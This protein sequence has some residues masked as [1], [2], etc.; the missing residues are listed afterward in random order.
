MIFKSLLPVKS[1]YSELYYFKNFSRIPN[2]PFQGYSS[3]LTAMCSCDDEEALSKCM[4]LGACFHVLKPLD[5]RSFSILWH[6][7]RWPSISLYRWAASW[8]PHPHTHSAKGRRRRWAQHTHTTNSSSAALKMWLNWTTFSIYWT[9]LNAPATAT[10]RLKSK[11][12]QQGAAA[13]TGCALC[14]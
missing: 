6:Q 13:T 5:R 4:N 1:L 14:T 9:Q 7:A 10:V 12:V 2:S 8:P 3:L 11:C